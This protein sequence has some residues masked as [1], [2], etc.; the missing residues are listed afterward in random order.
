M[1]NFTFRNMKTLW[2]TMLKINSP[3]K[4]VFITNTQYFYLPHATYVLE[5]ILRETLLTC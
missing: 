1:I 5:L 2:W 3:V 4:Y